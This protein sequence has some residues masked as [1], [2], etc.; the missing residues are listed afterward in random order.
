M[1]GTGRGTGWT[2]ED[3]LAEFA[4]QG[5]P[6]DPVRFRA[7]V[8]KVACLPRTG[9]GPSGEFGGRGQKRYDIGELQLLHAAN[10]RWLAASSP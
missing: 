5:M 9:E 6:V 4:T 3:A 1:S 7:A 10:L 8:I 2:I